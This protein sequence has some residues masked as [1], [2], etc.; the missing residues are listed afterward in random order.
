MPS[1]SDGIRLHS[2]T[3]IVGATARS[4]PNR[5]R[6]TIEVRGSPQW[7]TSI[8]SSTARRALKV[9]DS[10]KWKTPEERASCCWSHSHGR[11]RDMKILNYLRLL[12]FAVSLAVAPAQTTAPPK[13][14]RRRQ[15]LPPQ[16]QPSLWTLT[17][18]LRNNCRRCPESV[19]PMRTRSSRAGHTA[20]KMNSSTRRSFLK[21]PT[22]RSRTSSSR[23]RSKTTTRRGR[24]PGME[25]SLTG[26]EA[27]AWRWEPRGFRASGLYGSVCTFWLTP[28]L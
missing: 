26:S 22:I 12:L 25:S 13:A 20:G 9:P 3:F 16:R 24:V 1:A 14:V 18:P 7:I 15:L 2:H 28:A 27:G 10:S 23:S 5:R 8:S 17:L 19:Q 11:R 21:P 4:R 6:E